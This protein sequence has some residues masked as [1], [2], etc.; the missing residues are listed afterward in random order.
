MRR[1]IIHAP[2]IHVGGGVVLLKELLS[3]KCLGNVCVNLDERAADVISV[4]KWIELHYIPH[5]I[6]GRLKAEIYLKRISKKDDSVLCFHGLPPLLPVQGNIVVFAQNRLHF[7][8]ESLSQFALKT[9]LRITLERLICRLFKARVHEYI[10]QTQSMENALMKW[11]GGIPMIKIMPLVKK[12][13]RSKIESKLEKKFDFVYVADG[14][15]HKN[16][17]HLISA[18]ILLSEEEIFP[19]LCL[20]L[21]KRHEDIMNKIDVE[22]ANH[23]LKISNI[24]EVSHDVIINLYRSSTALIFP[25]TIESFGLPL[26]EASQLSLPIIASE[27]DFVRD[28]CTP[29]QTFDPQSP[30]S[31]SRAIKRF[32]KM[33]KQ[34]QQIYT[35][36]EFLNKIGFGE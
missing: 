21:S 17:H 31:I 32:L 10:V 28:V 1:L 25:S 2:G 34:T 15:F 22:I 35:S 12:L 36:S 18:L 6:I 9:R 26:L 20:T 8:S 27:K 24:G 33:T 5:S 4:P 14:E 23:D 29:V 13:E 30:I 3:E 11:H 16:H 19:S 7:E